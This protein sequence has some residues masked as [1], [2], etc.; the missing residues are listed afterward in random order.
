MQ[1]LLVDPPGQGLPA[2]TA[3]ML[4]ELGWDLTSAADY[5]SAVGATSRGEVDAVI[6]K[7][8]A[9]GLSGPEDSA[10]FEN[11]LRLAAAQ[12]VA[13]I[14]L[15]DTPLIGKPRPQ[16]V[17][18]T[19][20]PGV[21][22][23]ELR[24][25][26]A[27]IERYHAHFRR[28]ESELHNMERLSKRLN[29]HFR[30]VDQEMR[31]AARLQ[32]D[33]LP[34]VREPIDNVQFAAVYRPASWVSGDLFDVFRIDEDHTGFYVAD[35]VGH[36]MAASLLTMFIKRSISPKQVNGS[37]YTILSPTDVLASL[38]DALAEQELPNCQFVTAC[39][40]LIDH[41]TLTLQYSRGGHPYPI[42]ITAEGI[43]SELRSSGGLLGLFH[44][45]EFP[46]VETQ[47]RPGDKL[48]L[49]SDGVELAFQTTEDERLDTNA[50]QE[51]FKSMAS[52][53]IQE[54]VRA[55]DDRLDLETG[56]LNPHDD[57]TIVGLEILES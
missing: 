47:L 31:L 30:E 42:L 43:V 54:M 55:I 56:S 10:T 26:F 35:A 28:L 27:M 8:P 13:T 50:Y 49:F 14:I 40:G 11:L 3:G 32:R 21:S 51:A 24:G 48:L 12:Q 25:R 46:T 52:L 57:V 9:P 38:N 39:Y 29:E 37:S 33:F 7:A 15:T 6:V 2:G 22:V 53:S 45:G 16:S 34:D 18:E 20:S 5:Q 44:G 4:T 17:V 1:A 19:I 36:G 23:A 41:R